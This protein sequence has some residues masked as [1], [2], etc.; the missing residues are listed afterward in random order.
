MTL[1]LKSGESLEKELRVKT[2]FGKGTLYV[3]TSTIVIEI[4]KKGIVF[5]RHHE[6][7]ASITA[8]KNNKIKIFWPEGSQ[9]YDFEFKLGDAETHMKEIVE[10][11]NYEENFPDMMGVNS[12]ILSDKE[13]KKIIEKR[14]QM[15]NNGLNISLKELDEANLKVNMIASDDPNKTKKILEAVS[16]TSTLQ[17]DVTM[18]KNYIQDIPNIEINR[19]KKIPKDIPNHECWNDCWLD[20]KSDCI[21]TMN[22][23]FRKGRFDGMFDKYEPTKKFNKTNKV[24]NVIPIPTTFIEFLNG[25][26]VLK[27]YAS[28]ALQMPQPYFPTFTDNMLTDKIISAQFGIDIEMNFGVNPMVTG[29]PTMYFTSKGSRLILKNGQRYTFTR[30]ETVFLL[31]RKKISPEDKALLP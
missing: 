19:S 29:K 13:K 17:N 7:I 23:L 6:Q 8:P 26:P 24:P 1:I 30:K 11:H 20:R 4:D 3:T 28:E 15:A 2:S 27:K 25:Y 10:K 12:V 9:L 5:E 16:V 31:N 18:W 22:E 14:I 21:V